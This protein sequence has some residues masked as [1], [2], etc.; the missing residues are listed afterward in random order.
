[1][2]S[3]WERVTMMHVVYAQQEAPTTYSKSLFL[4]GPSRRTREPP[5]FL[6]D[7]PYNW[8]LDALTL[9]QQLNYDGVV[10]VPLPEDGKWNHSYESQIEWELQNLD[11]AD[12]IVF[13]VPREMPE[14]P[15]LTTNVEFGRYFDSGR[16]V[17]GFPPETQHMRYL[18]TTGRAEGVPVFHTLTETLTE[19]IKR[20]GT[21]APRTGGE[22]DVPLGIWKL[23]QF[24]SWY[25]AQVAAGN[26]LDSAKTLWTFRIGKNK[27]IT[28]AFALHVNVYIAAE[29]RNKRNEFVI[30]R[31]DIA[32]V[33]GYR[34]HDSLLDTEIALV[35]EFRSPAR[36]SDGFIRECPG[37]SSWKPGADPFLTMTHELEEETGLGPVSGFQIDSKRLRKFGSRQLCG[38]LS[39]H[40]AHVFACELTQIEMDY[41][42]L[43]QLNNTVHGVEADTER[44]YVEV[45]R[46]GDLLKPESNLVDWSTL[47][48]ILTVLSL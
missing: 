14:L 31:S 35:R 21:G 26:R 33:V 24:Q 32:T 39:T 47:G 43:Q 44:T 48:M 15:A 45:W 27:E 13:W 9:L 34:E 12:Q 11:R 5:P 23:P 8:R 36:T 18:E 42:K 16:V 28:V 41:L 1:V 2:P 29:E 25:Q 6:C 37:G 38:T 46:L 7:P 19:A 4:A 10:F 17:L 30:S 22:R 40:Q 3:L 20:I